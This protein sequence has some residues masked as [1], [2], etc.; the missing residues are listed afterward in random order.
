MHKL[1][2]LFLL[3]GISSSA[4]QATLPGNV[5]PAEHDG[6]L[7]LSLNYDYARANAGP[8][9]CGCFAMNGG[10][11]EA[12]FHAWRGFSAVA[13]LTGER[14]SSIGATAGDGLSLVSLTVGPRYTFRFRGEKLSHYSAFAQGLVGAAHGFDSLFPASNGS[15]AGAANSLAVL[16]GGGLD[17]PMSKHI[18]I[19]AFQ[20]DYLRTQLPNNASDEQNLLRLGAGV[21]LHP[22]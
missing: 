16:A 2:G 21:V 11:T 12:A 13:D 10:S 17:I 7:E 8:G 1:L 5:K 22:W 20:A 18:G 14:A 3:I 6:P 4:Q 19:R 9:Q 15:L